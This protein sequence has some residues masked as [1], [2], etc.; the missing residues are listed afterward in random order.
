MLWVTFLEAM[1]REALASSC[2][3]L[4][5]RGQP[6]NGWRGAGPWAHSALLPELGAIWR[7]AADGAVTGMMAEFF[8]GACPCGLASTASAYMVAR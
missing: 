2:A 7:I 3:R 8:A 1:A 6:C 4:G 5:V